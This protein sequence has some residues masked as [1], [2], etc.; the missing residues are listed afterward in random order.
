ML[1]QLL[2]KK[3]RKRNGDLYTYYGMPAGSYLSPPEYRT[4][5]SGPGQAVSPHV[6]PQGIWGAEGV[7]QQQMNPFEGNHAYQPYY[8]NQLYQQPSQNPYLMEQY[9]GSVPVN[10][11]MVDNQSFY[12]IPQQEMLNQYPK[13]QVNPFQNPLYSQDEDFHPSQQ[14]NIAI[15]NPY[16]KQSFMQKNQG[17]NLS[18]VL[19]QFKTQEGSIDFNKMIDTAGMM[20]NSMNQVSNLVKGVGSIFKVTT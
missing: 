15:T 4:I 5:Y 18:S 1:K 2:D 20:L 6:H 19:N 13:Q 16:P 10:G 8:H 9:P 17:N 7:Q 11:G 3:A 14:A 12:G